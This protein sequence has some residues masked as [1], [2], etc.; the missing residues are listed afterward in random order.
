MAAEG[1]DWGQA[2]ARACSGEITASFEVPDLNRV[3][4]REER[5]QHVQ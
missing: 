4:C 1:R 5:Q 3:S 2:G